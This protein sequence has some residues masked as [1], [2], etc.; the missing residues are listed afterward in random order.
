MVA[1][2]RAEDTEDRVQTASRSQCRPQREQHLLD[3]VGRR[4]QIENERVALT[5][6]QTL[7]STGGSGLRGQRLGQL[8]AFDAKQI[9]Q[10]EDRGDVASVVRPR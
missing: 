3:G 4:R 9:R 10:G 2:G 1:I 8:T 6:F 7:E 5:K